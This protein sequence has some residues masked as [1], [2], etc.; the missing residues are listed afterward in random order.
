M[1]CTVTP[2]KTLMGFSVHL[3]VQL[4]FYNLPLIK[5]FSNNFLVKVDK[6]HQ[7]IGLSS[8]KK[9]IPDFCSE[10]A[11][12]E[13]SIDT[14]MDIPEELVSPAKEIVQSLWNYYKLVANSKNVDAKQYAVD[15]ES[16]KQKVV[17]LAR[18]YSDILRRYI[19]G[20]NS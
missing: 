14:T 19:H 7:E 4:K 9:N 11:V 15:F 12:L 16:S 3:N 2:L 13:N 10:L 8:G 6:I 17:V 5:N 18:K 20:E 1:D